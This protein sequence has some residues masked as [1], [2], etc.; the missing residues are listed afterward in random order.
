[1]TKSNYDPKLDARVSKIIIGTLIGLIST[2][3]GF[4]IWI[5]TK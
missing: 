3:T 4:T 5:L 2:L 1:M